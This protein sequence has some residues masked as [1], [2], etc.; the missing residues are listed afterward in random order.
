MKKEDL[1]IVTLKIQN[2]RGIKAVE[3]SP[4]GNLVEITGKN[5]QGKTSVL[6][7]IFF[8][9]AGGRSIPDDVVR[10]GE[11]KARI[12]LDTGSFVV[13]KVITQDSAKLIITTEGGF[14]VRTPQSFLDELTNTLAYNPLEFSKMKGDEQVDALC[15]AVGIDIN[16]FDDR[17]D[18][19][20]DERRDVGVSRKHFKGEMKG[21][22]KDVEGMDEVEDV[23]T[24]ELQERRDSINQKLGDDEYLHRQMDEN[25]KRMEE[26]KEKIKSLK[27]KLKELEGKQEVLEVK[28]D[29]MVSEI[30]SDKQIK[31]LQDT[32]EKIDNRLR[33]ASKVEKYKR[34]VEAKKKYEETDKKYKE[35]SE[36]LSGIKD[37]KQKAIEEVD[38]P[39]E[40]LSIEDGSITYKGVK[41]EGLSD[42][43]KLRVSVG[44][45]IAQNPSFRVL[46]IKDGVYL[47]SGNMKLLS[48]L[49]EKH[50]FQIWVETIESGNEE[51]IVIEAGEVK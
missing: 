19:L 43:E 51:A 26:M 6:K 22:E 11:N 18:K 49:A 46:L 30:L 28:Q 34:F 16:T 31:K 2:I 12:E 47:D 4:D 25:V 41:F 5:E 14:E 36:Q 29:K 32:K 9:L 27:A 50:D 42:S 39:V 38:M 8:A 3:V 24:G 44:I 17:Y 13:E 37:E 48:E 40:G 15:D 35:M 10:M 33:D 1:K 23:D 7:S 45:A 21:L 20:Y